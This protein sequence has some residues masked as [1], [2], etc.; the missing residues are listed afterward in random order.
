LRI[1]FGGEQATRFVDGVGV[2]EEKKRREES[3]M[4]SSV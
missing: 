2:R 4:T 1:Y 3:G